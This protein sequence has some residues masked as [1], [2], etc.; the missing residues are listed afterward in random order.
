MS[1]I[2]VQQGEFTRAEVLDTIR[3]FSKFNVNLAFMFGKIHRNELYKQ[4]GFSSFNTWVQEDVCSTKNAIISKS[5]AYMLKRIGYIFFDYQNEITLSMAGS[6][7]AT[8]TRLDSLAKA[9]ERGQITIPEAIRIV[10]TMDNAK[11]EEIAESTKEVDSEGLTSIKTII[12]VGDEPIY[13]YALMLYALLNGLSS[14]SDAAIEMIIGEIPE[15]ESHVMDK[16]M[17]KFL[18]LLRNNTFYCKLCNKIPN[19]PTVHHMVPR[20]LGKGYGPLAL[21]CWEPCHEQIVQP[22]WKKYLEEWTGEGYET[23][24][25]RIDATI[26]SNNSTPPSEVSESNITEVVQYVGCSQEPI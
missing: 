16:S 9:V 24:Q 19:R 23:H 26:G 18:P 3:N 20:S 21:L 7:W 22:N 5:Y 17:G 10:E 14:L 11:M 2:V 25:Q 8:I 4:W 1:D 15:L 12:K 13:R 6:G